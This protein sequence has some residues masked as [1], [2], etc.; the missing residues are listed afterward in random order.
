MPAVVRR[1]ERCDRDQLITLI[2]LHVAAVI[3]ASCSRSTRCCPSW[4]VS[5]VKAS[6]TRG[7]RAVLLGRR[8]RAAHRCGSVAAPVPRRRPP[9]GGV[10]A[11]RRPAVRRQGLRRCGLRSKLFQIRPMVD[12][13][14]SV[15]SAIFARD[16]WVACFGVDYKAATMTS[17]TCSAVI[18]GGFPGRGSST[19]PSSRDSTNRQRHLPTVGSDTL[20]CAATSVLLRPPAQAN[21]IHER[22]AKACENFRRRAHRPNYSV[23][24]TSTT[25][26]LSGAL[27]ARHTL[28]DSKR[29]SGAGH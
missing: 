11:V 9:R 14:S 19:R 29:I 5:L 18:V 12:L 16:Q 13:D 25:A 1:F 6:S 24:Q 10:Q 2:N 15:R 26:A 17:S 27:S 7:R 22:N 21:T 20:R 28:S 4:S 8:P 3:R 23:P